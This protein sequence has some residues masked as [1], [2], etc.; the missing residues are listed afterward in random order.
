MV[1]EMNREYK[2]VSMKEVDMQ[3]I[4]TYGII[5]NLYLEADIEDKETK[6]LLQQLYYHL[7]KKIYPYID[8]DRDITDIKAYVKLIYKKEE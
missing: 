4:I 5:K 1:M 3:E 7:D 8:T 2:N 6:N